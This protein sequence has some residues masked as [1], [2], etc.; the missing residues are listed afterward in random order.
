MNEHL[1]TDGKQEFMVALLNARCAYLIKKKQEQSLQQTPQATDRTDSG[2]AN[3]KHTGEQD[4]KGG[5]GK[6]L[7]KKL[8][9]VSDKST[10][11]AQQAAECGGRGENES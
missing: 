6:T 8:D 4:A 10:R 11:A 7:S 9:K 5:R 3:E 2:A 1:E